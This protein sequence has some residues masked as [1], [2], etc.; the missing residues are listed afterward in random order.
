MPAHTEFHNTK[1]PNIKYYTLGKKTYYAYAKYMFGKQYRQQGFFTAKEAQ[2]AL[3]EKRAELEKQKEDE[4]LNNP[5]K[6]QTLGE[7]L[8]LIA[9]ENL[10][11][12]KA[13]E[14]TT[15]EKI[16]AINKYLEPVLELKLKD[17][18][19]PEMNYIKEVIDKTPLEY[20]RK[21]HLI[22]CVRG[23]FKYG[24]AND[25]VEK[26]YAELG[27]TKYKKSKALKNAEENDIDNVKQRKCI[28]SKN[29]DK[30]MNAMRQNERKNVSPEK[31]E[32]MIDLCIFLYHTGLRINEAL[33]LTFECITSQGDC[34]QIKNQINKN[35]I[36]KQEKIKKEFTKKGKKLID[37][38]RA[39]K[40]N[41]LYSVCPL[42]SENSKRTVYLDQESKDILQK[43]QK[44]YKK[45]CPELFIF[46]GEDKFDDNAL[47]RAL[48]SATYYIREVNAEDGDSCF[49]RYRPHDFRHTRA[50]YLVNQV[51]AVPA[52]AKLLGH[53]L[54]MLIKVYTHDTT[55]DDARLKNLIES[56][57]IVEDIE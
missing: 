36:E 13:N 42:K 44:A 20:R 7:V 56:G 34:I 26:N 45:Y 11:T 1:Y 2:D 15:K 8:L 49:R 9:N 31:T 50:T 4:T 12:G 16:I 21:N 48:D 23:A 40:N 43:Y 24:I 30:L 53:T 41:I 5:F 54:D 55:E 38:G 37:A 52:V 57:E 19:A 51:G 47:Y 17:I 29:F 28:S 35:S 32:M 3:L 22:Q 27:L 25:I 39:S 46:G 6:N 33:S 18:K 14:R 10:R